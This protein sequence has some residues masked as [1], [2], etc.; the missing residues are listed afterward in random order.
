MLTREAIKV[1]HSKLDMVRDIPRIGIELELFCIDNTTLKTVPYQAADGHLSMQTL[2]E[3]LKVHEGYVEAGPAKTFMLKKDGSKLSLEPGAQLE[4]CST[5]YADPE[6][7]LYEFWA[8]CAVLKRL[9]SRFNISWLDISYF[10][11]GDSA[12]VALLPSARC[13]IIDRYWQH[14]GKLGRDLMRYTT[15][16]HL[17][18]DYD[19][20]LDLAKKVERALFL[21]PIFLFLSASSRIRQGKDTGYRSFRTMI[22]K[23]TDM[24]RTGTP[25]SESLWSSGQW[26]LN[27]Y[28]EKVL[29]APAIFAMGTSTYTEAAHKPFEEY[30]NDAD[31]D[32]YLSHLATIYTDIRVRQY[33]EVRYLDNPGIRL[34][35]G[36]ILL[37][38][39]LF[40]DDAVW[41]DFEGRM[42][43]TFQEVPRITELLNTASDA[44][45]SYWERE[46]LTPMT[47]FLSALQARIPSAWSEH[48]EVVSERIVNYKKHDV[49]PD[50]MSEKDIIAY[51]KSSFPF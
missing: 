5:P 12:D 6:A 4:F 21:K 10:P 43:Y 31:F 22:Y 34:L 15:S 9:S 28:I 45:N 19:T 11:V 2:F 35:P 48:L 39:S 47:E 41:N 16:L 40:Y 14:T 30:L 1:Y 17:S 23:D 29:K 33:L 20:P 49:L 26:R 25:G 51:F 13:E 42:P 18:F 44:S 50:T 38:Y 32:D 46:L 3:Y 24:P 27:D 36:I 8:Y 37:F 7:L